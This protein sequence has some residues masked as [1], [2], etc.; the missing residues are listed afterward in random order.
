MYWKY[1]TRT[2]A[3]TIILSTC[4]TCGTSP[5]AYDSPLCSRMRPGDYQMVQSAILTHAKS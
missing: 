1:C 2:V 4:G 3:H 5:T